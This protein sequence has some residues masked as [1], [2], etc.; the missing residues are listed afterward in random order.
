VGVDSTSLSEA[1]RH[2]R[3]RRRRGWLGAF[4][5]LGLAIVV[6][7]WDVSDRSFNNWF[8]HH[9]L[10]TS[11][12]STLLG[13]GVGALVIDRVAERRQL[14]ERSRV[15]ASQSAIISGQAVR[16]TQAA[17]AALGGTGERD[18]ASDELRTLATLL[19]MGSEVLLQSYA[20]RQLLENCNQLAALL[21]N[22]L[23]VTVV[24]HLEATDERIDAA[25]ERVRASAAPIVAQ[26]SSEQRRA[27]P[28]DALEGDGLDLG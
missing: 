7:V 13:L 9:A 22:A 3:T 14:R 1:D 15:V 21:A 25:L 11:I 2:E 8:Y 24:A 27:V 16:T 28:G 10:T 19:M 17:K 20:T 18:A 12:L 26:L 23:G 6:V 4:G 5:A